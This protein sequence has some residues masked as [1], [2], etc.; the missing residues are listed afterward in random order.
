[1]LERD[2][3]VVTSIACGPA[4]F[5]C[6]Q[7]EPIMHEKPRVKDRKELGALPMPTQ[8]WSIVNWGRDCWNSRIVIADVHETGRQGLGIADQLECRGAARRYQTLQALTS[9]VSLSSVVESTLIRT[10]GCGGAGLR[11]GLTSLGNVISRPRYPKR[12]LEKPRW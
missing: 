6:N 2:L 12:C 3:A 4:I 11:R 9:V 1:M 5:G 10:I 8:L 7:S